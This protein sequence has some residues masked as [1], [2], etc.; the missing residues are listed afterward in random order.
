MDVQTLDTPA[1]DSK[2]ESKTNPGIDRSNLLW[3]KDAI[4]YQVHVR[5]FY[6]SNDDGIGDFQGLIQ[7]L[8]YLSSLGV[9]AIWI[10]PFYPSP[11]RDDGYDIADYTT[12]NPSYGTLEDFQQVVAEAHKRNIRVI[13]EL[14]I[15]HTSDQHEWFQKSR[16]APEGSY[17]RDF[18]VW[19]DNPNKYKGTRI[20]FKDFEHS[21]WTWDPVAKS[22]FWHRFYSHQPDLNFD[23]PEVQRVIFETMDYWMDMGVDGMRLDAIPYLFEREGT[24]N[25]NLPET[26]AFL[27]KLRAHVDSKYPGRMLLA[28]AN[29]WPE[30]AINYFGNG[31]ECHMNFHFPLMP[32]LFMALKMEDRFSII[33]ILN[34]T[35]EIPDTC[36]WATFLRNHDELTLEMVTDEERDYMYKVYA[37]D[38]RARI[39]LGVRR[40]LAPLVGNDRR[41]IELLNSLLFSLPG[42]PIIYYGDEIGMGDNIYLGDRD[43]VRTPFQWSAD[44][45]A[46]F[47]RANPQRLYLPVISSPEYNSEAINVENS[48]ANPTSLFWWMQRLISLRSTYPELSRGK[49]EFISSNNPKVLTFVR[50]HENSSVLCVVNLSRNAQYVELDLARFKGSVPME[51]FGQTD[52]PPIG[53]LPY[54]LTLGPYAFYWFQLQEKAS[55]DTGQ[56]LLKQPVILE[57]NP[58]PLKTLSKRENWARFERNLKAYL[59]KTRWFGGKGRKIA[60]IEL[61]DIF[62]VQQYER[63]EESALAL[64]TVTYSEGLAETYSIP[65]SFAEGERA[66]RIQ[67]DR[68]H[69]VIAQA[70]NGIFYEAILDGA[71][72]QA[73]LQMIMNRKT[74]SGK[75]GK[76]VTEFIG[77]KDSEIPEPTLAGLEQSNSSMMFG[78]K[79]YLKMYRRFEDGENPEI[80]IGRF[81]SAKGFKETA[82]YLGSLSYSSSGKTYSLAVV[83]ELVENESDGW[84]M[85]LGQVSQL[86]ERLVSE[87]ASIACTTDRPK[88]PLSEM[89]TRQP[90]EDYQHLAGY[91]LGLARQLGQRTADMHRALGVEDRNSNFIPEPFTPFYQRSMYQSFR[92]LTDRTTD[93]LRKALPQLEGSNRQMAEELLTREKEIYERFSYVKSNVIDGFR[94]RVHGDYHLGQVIFTGTDFKI[95]DFEGEPARGLGERRLKRMPLKDV[96]G[97]LRSFDYAAEFHLR[98]YVLRDQDREKLEPCL[99]V[100]ST[101]MSSEFLNAYLDSMRES[102]LLPEAIDQ[103][104]AVLQIYVLEKALYEIGYELRNRPDWV[105]IPLRGVLDILERAKV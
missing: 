47:S 31:D 92:N 60:K 29:Q 6:D 10:M 15:N 103:I 3:Y 57:V 28:E 87:G 4:I 74:V 37:S 42:S 55:V 11:L 86:S 24:S 88:A 45:N 91:T 51:L 13:T 25:E 64:A 18:Y 41:Q 38:P 2:T 43:G 67:T 54:F 49:L 65:L 68:P 20:I 61:V 30:D 90:S 81:L 73:M 99:K 50:T 9:T 96:A 26:H 40:R 5:A 17:W 7:K 105:G 79:Y 14:V 12:V 101:W 35:P 52:F 1:S 23:N 58:E 39:N 32:R 97:M 53:D 62:Y 36:Q 93:Q 104:D 48:A 85:M 70:A 95:I 19:S 84:T 66:D 100:W 98:K 77:Q 56:W 46:G 27:K 22:Y 16:R 83:Q 75:T 102:G 44:R 63:Q 78:K 94:I 8:D 34:Q 69:M 76:L 21:N 80:E 72:D 33:D 89:R 82:P 71:F 59:P